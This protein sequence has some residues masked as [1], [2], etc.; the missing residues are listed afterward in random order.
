MKNG[1]TLIE[2][3]VTVAIFIILIFGVSAML[4]N[5]FVNS[6]QELLS[7]NT[8]DQ[9]RLALATFTN[10][11]RNATTGSDG[12]YP[13]S[14][15]GDFQIIFYSNFGINPTII[16]RIR[17]Y[18][19]GNTLYKGVVLPA[20]SPLSYNLS[21]ES[22]TAV[23]SGVSNGSFPVFYYYDGNYNGTTS[24]ISQPVNINNVRY[25]KI[26]LM[27]L[28]QIMPNSASSFLVTAGGTI[29]S[30]KNNLGN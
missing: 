3:V 10:E 11:I 9:A 24:A 14:Q 1:F 2:I 22:V 29:R 15:A 12:S 28:N 19:S 5:I 27:V 6:K 13:L 17:Y 20:G 16:K 8:I 21:S 18:I 23:A 4:N 7:I 25:V 30:I 26:N